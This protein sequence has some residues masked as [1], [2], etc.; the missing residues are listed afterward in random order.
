[1]IDDVYF[2]SITD[3]PLVI[4]A[5]IKSGRCEINNSILQPDKKNIQR[6]LRA[7]GVFPLEIV[8]DVA[9]EIYRT[10][11]YNSEFYRIA[12]CCLGDY[13]NDRIATDL[14]KAKQIFWDESILPFIYNRFSEYRSRKGDH[15]QWEITGKILWNASVESRTVGE[16]IAL[17]KNLWKI[18]NNI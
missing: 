14:P 8:D 9:N 6:L 13:S 2:S 4:I 16:Y 18:S 17:I 15:D 1:M 12:I 5:E 7:I 3:K 10:G 11:G